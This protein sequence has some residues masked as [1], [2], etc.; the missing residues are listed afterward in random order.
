VIKAEVQRHHNRSSI[1]NHNRHPHLLSYNTGINSSHRQLR[2]IRA[3]RVYRLPPQR[4]HRR[5]HLH[6]KHLGRK[7]K[8]NDSENIRPIHSPRI[9]VNPR[10]ERQHGMDSNDQRRIPKSQPH[11]Q[12]VSIRLVLHRK[13]GNTLGKFHPRRLYARS[14][15]HRTLH[16]LN[17]KETSEELKNIN[18]STRL[19]HASKGKTA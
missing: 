11:R 1:T 12:P 8:K 13:T 4:H 5:L 16:R 7:Q 19:N 10:G 17:A 6:S 3:Q 15:L 14:Q 18:T 2:G 9:V